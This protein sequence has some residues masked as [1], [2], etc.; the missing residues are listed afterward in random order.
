[1][2]LDL[3]SFTESTGEGTLGRCELTTTRSTITNCD[4][5][6]DDA[7][8]Y[9][10]YGAGTF[11][12]YTIY[13]DVN[14]S[15]KSGAYGLT[16]FATLA[17]SLGDMMDVSTDETEQFLA[18]YTR[19]SGGNPVAIY[20]GQW[21]SGNNEMYT[22][23]SL[24]L[25]IGTTYYLTFYRRGTTCYCKIYSDSTR[26]TLIE[27]LTRTGWESTPWRYFYCFQSCD[28]P[29]AATQSF[30]TENYLFGQED[31]ILS[32]YSTGDR[33]MEI[34]NRSDKKLGIGYSG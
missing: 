31:K 16:M 32:F 19:G 10:D 7:Y 25:V 14:L 15:A 34:F 23:S 8:A 2:T 3:T 33:R 22:D 27:T 11:T 26:A 6:D 21:T 4:R 18:L 24:Q 5:R 1:M 9:H 17:N 29:D 12:N 30:Y 20:I 28:G 13:L